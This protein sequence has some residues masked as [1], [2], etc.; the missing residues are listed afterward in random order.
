MA[1]PDPPLAPPPS[2]AR[3]A[4]EW[5]RIGVIGFGGP[6]VHM[7][8]LRELVVERE[9]WIDRR[10]FE[11]AIAAAGLLP[12]PAST[13]LAIYCARR[14]G[15]PRGAL[16]GAAGFILPG[17]LAVLALAAVFLA[18][19][20][21][22]W[23]LAAA[24]GGGAAVPA[25]AVHA[26]LQLLPDS[27]ARARPGAGARRWL[28]YAVA[29]ALGAAFVGPAVVLV[30]LGAGLTELA[31]RTPRG[32]D[33]RGSP[34]GPRPRTATRDSAS[35]PPDGAAAVGLPVVASLA[36]AAIGTSTAARLGWTAF[37]VGALSYGGGFV[38]VPLMQSDAVERYGW[39][40]DPQFLSA[41]AIGQVTPGP[42]VNTIAAVGW[43]AGGIGG[44]LLAAAIAFG[45]SVLLIATAGHRFE[46]L[47]TSAHAQAFLL[48]SGP[49]ALGAILGSAVP[50]ASSLT[51]PWQWVLALVAGAAL[52]GARRGV[53][54]TL[55]AAAVIGIVI[56][57][58]GGEI[59]R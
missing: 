45:P 52:I 46:Q 50:L 35:P 19:S 14:L 59:P 55:L 4:R 7:V 30:L 22:L 40:T 24:A 41:V 1:A 17:L 26:G 43:S 18:A 10:E 28:A 51:E 12:G 44:A 2:S 27:R 49:A 54:P 42:V 36:A 8:L 37:K 13:Q 34:T 16:I 21:P 38:I 53:V 15:G 58:A 31:W 5:T 56:G 20:P 6:P 39:M 25:V 32:D 48:G 11:D 29:G 47:R 23:V 3:I 33:E 9:R 57:A